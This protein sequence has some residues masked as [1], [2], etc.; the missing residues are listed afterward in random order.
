MKNYNATLLQDE[1][2]YITKKEFKH[3]RTYEV[4]TTIEIVKSVNGKYYAEVSRTI[5]ADNIWAENDEY[6]CWVD[7]PNNIMTEENPTE[8]EYDAI[9][10][11]FRE[12]II[13]NGV[14]YAR[15]C[16]KCGCGMNEGYVIEGGVEYYCTPKC[17]HEVY[18]PKEWQ[19]MYEA[20]DNGNSDNY[21]TE[22]E[23]ESCYIL[24]DNQLINI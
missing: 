1:E 3:E 19:D 11:T 12:Y 8:E 16:D 7:E 20:E 18:T 13:A 17:L 9:I 4:F 15:V 14:N 23:G 2:R 5:D 6:E 21:W 22:W 24:F 10:E